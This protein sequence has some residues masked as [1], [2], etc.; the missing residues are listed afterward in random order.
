[1]RHKRWKEIL[2]PD[3]VP[4]GPGNFTIIRLVEGGL[5]RARRLCQVWQDGPRR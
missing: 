2:E 5:V 3:F 4:K 1:M